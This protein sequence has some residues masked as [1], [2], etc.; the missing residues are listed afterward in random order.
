MF[1]IIFLN[2]VFII[3]NVFEYSFF[4]VLSYPNNNT[5]VNFIAKIK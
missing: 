2:I 1:Y 5:Q 3:H 4:L